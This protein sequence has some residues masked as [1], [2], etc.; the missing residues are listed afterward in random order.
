MQPEPR[1]WIGDDNILRVAFPQ[2]F[3]LTLEAMHYTHRQRML[4]APEKRPLLV[5][6]GLYPKVERL[7]RLFN[8]GPNKTESGLAS[9]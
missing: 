4:V 9:V 3:H 8:A 7:R 1:V 5:Q 6:L 2:D